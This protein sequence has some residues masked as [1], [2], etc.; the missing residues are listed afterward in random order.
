MDENA[1]REFD[2]R[3]AL[4]TQ[5]WNE[6]D[7]KAR[8]EWRLTFAI[9]AALG[10]AALARL[11]VSSPISPDLVV[12]VCAALL[13]LHTWFLGW[14][15]GRLD[16]FRVEFRAYRSRMPAELIVSD[17][18]Q[19]QRQNFIR[20]LLHPSVLVQLMITVLLSWILWVVSSVAPDP[21]FEL[22]WCPN[23]ESQCALTQTQGAFVHGGF[24]TTLDSCNNVV[25]HLKSSGTKVGSACVELPRK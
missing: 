4:A 21:R 5:A 18:P 15:H 23:G 2:A 20:R 3:H 22:R 19:R 25:H 1:K 16:D 13:L 10:A 17:A 7:H 8:H 11:T 14:I 9:W 6:W 24:F 12:Y